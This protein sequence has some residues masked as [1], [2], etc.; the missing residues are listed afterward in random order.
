MYISSRN[1]YRVACL[2]L[3]VTV[4]AILISSVLFL[5]MTFSMFPN[6]PIVS[7]SVN[8]VAAILQKA[9]FRAIKH[10][11]RSGYPKRRK[12][13]GKT[14][15][16]N[17]KSRLENSDRE[18][19]RARLQMLYKYEGNGKGVGRLLNA[20]L[21]FITILI[22]VS[23]VLAA[24]WY[25]DICESG[26]TLESMENW[27]VFLIRNDDNDNVENDV[28]EIDGWHADGR[29]REQYFSYLR[30]VDSV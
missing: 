3:Y 23:M 8:N 2:S 27:S 7:H 4:F 25:P 21:T 17:R 10:T 18:N 5:L 12:S 20:F 19:I 11:T 9:R 16:L 22:C 6:N 30:M 26:T 15:K 13:K 14:D 28:E 24:L 1:K 29:W